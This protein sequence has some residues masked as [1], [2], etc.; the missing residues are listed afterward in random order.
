[1]DR[2]LGRSFSHDLRINGNSRTVSSP[3][4]DGESSNI[5]RGSITELPCVW[6]STRDFTAYDNPVG[7]G[8]EMTYIGVA[9]QKGHLNRDILLSEGEW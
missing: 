7:D 8:F 2:N 4:E 6:L 9:D 1:M 3:Y 5:H